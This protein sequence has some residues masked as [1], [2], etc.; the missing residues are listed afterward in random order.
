MASNRFS[1]CVPIILILCATRGNTQ[2]NPGTQALPIEDIKKTVVYLQGDYACHEPRVINGVQALAPD[3]TPIYET[4]CREVGTGFLM[5]YMTP[6]LGPNR[7]V[8]LLVTSKHVLQHQRLGS[9]VG[10]LEYFDKVTVTANGRNLNTDGSFITQIPVS[11]KDHGFLVCSIDDNDNDA[12]LAVCPINISDTDF[13]IEG[14]PADIAVTKAKIQSLMLNETDD[15]LFSGLFL[16]YHGAKKNYPIVRH[17]KIALIPEERIPWSSYPG[18][19]SMQDLYLAEVTSWGGNSGSPVF[20]RLS[21]AREQGGLYAGV[22]YLLLGVM[23]GYFNSERLAA[24]DTSAVTD[25][26]HFEV[27]LSDNSGIAAIVPAEKILETMA[28]PRVKGTV[29]IFRGIVFS[30]AG[31]SADAEASFK[32]A[33]EVL[34]TSDPGHR[35]LRTALIFYAQ[36]LRDAGRSAEASFQ[37]RLASGMNQVSNVPDDQ[38]R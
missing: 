25:T 33:I 35:L 38:L 2:S 23:Q 10:T 19:Q 17:G 11:V 22:Q 27:K 16:P 3:G 21:G 20:V 36:V 6:E 7:G 18:Q 4:V 24:L 15:V 37:L 29:A 12:D 30:K 14:I 9:P 1:A 32:Q 5:N 31:R 8:P 34:R 13:D 28:Q 26:A